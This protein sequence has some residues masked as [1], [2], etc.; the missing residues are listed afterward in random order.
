MDKHIEIFCK[1]NPI[2]ECKCQECNTINKIPMKELLKVKY[3]YT[4]T[5][6]AC[7]KNTKIDTHQFHKE[8]DKLKKFV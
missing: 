3:E 1:N 7:N 4:M 5:C 8:L 6:C 2:F